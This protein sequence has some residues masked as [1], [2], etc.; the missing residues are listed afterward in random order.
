M[1]A[2]SCLQTH[3]VSFF[4]RWNSW[5]MLKNWDTGHVDLS[6]QISWKIAGFGTHGPSSPGAISWKWGQASHLTQGLCSSAPCGPTCPYCAIS[7]LLGSFTQLATSNRL[8]DAF[9]DNPLST[10]HCASLL[11]Y[12]NAT[13]LLP[14]RSSCINQLI[15]VQWAKCSTEGMTVAQHGVSA[16]R[17]W[18][19]V[20]WR[21]LSWILKDEYE[22]FR[23][24]VGGEYCKQWGWNGEHL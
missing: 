13:Q 12:L 4:L 14:W 17:N 9:R 20:L 23:Q 8:R 3:A 16:L 1:E 21:S 7:C 10:R 11:E 18:L 19:E 22:W 2:R 24:V 5:L 15:T 6:F